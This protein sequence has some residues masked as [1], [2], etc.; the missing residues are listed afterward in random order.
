MR[1]DNWVCKYCGNCCITYLKGHGAIL[2]KREVKEELYE[3][4][5]RPLEAPPVMNAMYSDK[6][7]IKTKP[8]YF[9]EFETMIEVCF[10]LDENTRKC[11]IHDKRPHICQT[12]NCK[13]EQCNHLWIKYFGV[14]YLGEKD[15]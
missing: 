12:F 11:T 7:V 1:N 8:I 15:D 10:Y 6:K 14:P 5:D 4:Q 2:T 3:M 9:E 13:G